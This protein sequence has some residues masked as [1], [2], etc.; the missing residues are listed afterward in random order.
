[1]VGVSQTPRGSRVLP[2]SSNSSLC[3]TQDLQLLI[4]QAIFHRLVRFP[5]PQRVSPHPGDSAWWANGLV[6]MLTEG[7]SVLQR[8]SSHPGDNH[9]VEK[10]VMHDRHADRLRLCVLEN[11]VG[12]ANRITRVRNRGCQTQKERE[13]FFSQ[14]KVNCRRLPWRPKA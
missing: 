1:M 3:P 2:S 7:L 6:A 8:E 13:L 14:T 4:L 11:G 12:Y 10:G 5:G 9:S